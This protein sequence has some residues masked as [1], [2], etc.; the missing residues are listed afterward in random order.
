MKQKKTGR[1]NAATAARAPKPSTH[2]DYLA[3]LPAAQRAALETIRRTI[4]SAAP[5]A[6]ECIRYRIPAF[7]LDGKRLVFYGAAANH[8]ALYAVSNSVLEAF[9]DEVKGYDTSGKGTLRFP[10]H[11]PKLTK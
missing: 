4:R 10:A 2:D 11:P 1:T 7:R 8:C 6:E 5:E 9:R 3:A